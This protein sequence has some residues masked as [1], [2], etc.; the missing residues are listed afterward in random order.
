MTNFSIQTT[1]PTVGSTAT[2]SIARTRLLSG[3]SAQNFAHAVRFQICDD[4]TYTDATNATIAV[5]ANRGAITQVLTADKDIEVISTGP[6]AAVGVLTLTGSVDESETVTIGTEVYEFDTNASV[7]PGNIAVDISASATAAQGTLTVDT[8]PTAFDTLTVGNRTY[9]FVPDGDAENPGEISVGSDLATAQA[10]IEG[11]INGTDGFNVANTQVT[12]GSFAADAAII[13]AISAGTGG[14]AVVTTETFTAGTNSFDGTTLGTT[15]P[16][17]AASASD[18][19]TA[20]VGAITANSALVDAVDG[21]GDTVEL[22]AKAVGAAGN[23]I[24][25]VA[26]LANGSFGAATLENGTDS[27]LSDIEIEITNAVAETVTLRVGP[28]QFDGI[29]SRFVPNF[30]QI[31]HV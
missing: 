29:P 1:L 27:D 8:Q 28:P 3:G 9:V 22:T 5:V 21:A 26:A 31:T 16:G 4:G 20:L 10:N 2:P 14:N 30:V 18:A 25:T 23:S 7:S 12:I 19:V 13:T 6:S 24:A 11:A 17:A 15:T